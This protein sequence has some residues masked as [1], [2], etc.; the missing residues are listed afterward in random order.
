M[1]R[2]TRRHVLRAGASAGLLLTATR[3]AAGTGDAAR[4]AAPPAQFGSAP[5]DAVFMRSANASLAAAYDA[6]AQAFN[7]KQTR[8]RARFEAAALGQGET[9]P[10]KL[11][12]MLASDSAPDCF[13]VE[14]A[15]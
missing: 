12:T 10:A 14:Q 1:K 2:P 15:N 6:Q 8:V 11:T 7:R 4:D 5:I 9:W 13:L 3:C